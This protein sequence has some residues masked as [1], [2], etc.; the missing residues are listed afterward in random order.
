MVVHGSEVGV[1]ASV[2]ERAITGVLERAVTFLASSET[3]IIHFA[4]RK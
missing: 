4:R 1:L 2:F 3:S